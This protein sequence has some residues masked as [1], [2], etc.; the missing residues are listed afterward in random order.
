MT[1]LKDR[2]LSTST[3]IMFHSKNFQVVGGVVK[4]FLKC[5]IQTLC[6]YKKYT[7]ASQGRCF[8]NSNSAS[9]FPLKCLPFETQSCTKFPTL[10]SET[11]HFTF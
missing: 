8:G 4:Q 1:G 9:Y 10:L 3:N 7:Y 2:G 5:Y 6:G 11:T